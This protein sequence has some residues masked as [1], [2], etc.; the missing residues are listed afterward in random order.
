MPE[1]DNGR[2]YD[3][4]VLRSLLHCDLRLNDDPGGA[5]STLQTRVGQIA[6][7]ASSSTYLLRP[8]SSQA[9]NSSVRTGAGV[10]VVR[11]SA[12]Q[13][14]HG[15]HCQSRPKQKRPNATL[16]LKQQTQMSHNNNKEGATTTTTTAA[17]VT[18]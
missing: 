6:W 13:T 3:Q 1:L 18:R 16:Q 7:L 9:Y 2:V 15:S 10:G 14:L 4:R 5:A 12:F 17:A 8:A 11:Y